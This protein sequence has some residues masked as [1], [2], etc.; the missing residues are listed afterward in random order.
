MQRRQ[1]SLRIFLCFLL[2]VSLN[3]LPPFAKAALQRDERAIRVILVIIY[4][5]HRERPKAS[6]KSALRKVVAAVS[7]RVISIMMV[8]RISRSE[9]RTPPSGL[10]LVLEPPDDAFGSATVRPD[11]DFYWRDFLRTDEVRYP[12][13]RCL[14]AGSPKH[15]HSDST[16][17]CRKR[18]WEPIVSGGSSQGTVRTNVRLLKL[19]SAGS[20]KSFLKQ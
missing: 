12:E 19:L 20:G 11:P 18:K 17:E 16:P 15:M 2:A 7:L 10:R 14:P 1:T 13:Y 4:P 3:L 5:I 6:K 9:N 8:L